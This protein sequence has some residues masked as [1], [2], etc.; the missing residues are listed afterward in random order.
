MR[1]EDI[2][3]PRS[4]FVSVPVE[5]LDCAAELAER[6]SFEAIPV[7]RDGHVAGYWS[8]TA[9]K[10]KQINRYHRAQHDDD[11]EQLLPRLA[12]HLIQFVHYHDQIVGLV[13][14]SDLNKPMARLIFLGRMLDC[15]QAIF[16]ATRES[17]LREEQVIAALGRDAAKGAMT[18][19]RKATAEDLDAP[20]LEFAQFPDVLRAATRLGLISLDGTELDLLTSIRNR[21][22][23]ATHK[24]VQR[25]ADTRQDGR[26]GA[27]SPA[28]ARA[29]WDPSGATSLLSRPSSYTES[30][31]SG[32]VR[33]G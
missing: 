30:G 33:P 21:S 26:R 25:Q 22:A 31:P 4:L 7:L 6:N 20:L 13:D 11:V 24:L 18:R 27:V 16:V 32:S 8:R 9:G 17:Q 1:V 15:E 10:V 12:E 3:T 23:H 14:V 28:Q 2:M 19:R 5:R 29:R